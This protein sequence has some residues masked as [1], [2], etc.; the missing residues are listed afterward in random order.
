MGKLRNLEHTLNPDAAKDVIA[1]Q[2]AR[3]LYRVI[4]LENGQCRFEILLDAVR[5][6]TLRTAVDAQTADW[7]RQTQYDHATPL[8][9][10][11]RTTE[12]INAHALTRIA[13]IF[14][15]APA[16]VREANFNPPMLF[17]TP[18]GKDP[19]TLAE[20]VYGTPVPTSA[21]PHPEAH[22]LELDDTGHP[23]RLDGAQI[24]T[25]PHTRLASPAQRTA[26]AHRDRHCTEPGCTRPPTFA[27][28]AHHTIPHSKGGPTTLRN[29][30]LLCSPHHTLAH[31]HQHQ[32]QHQQTGHDPE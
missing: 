28:H 16:N 24:D 14:L 7:I 21:I 29:M 20:T 23:T 30:V 26:L 12:Q 6:T 11:I 31:Q 19:N 13:E 18:A 10:D 17:S 3:S 5:A 25:D 8:P 2:R 4:E 1:R 22:T 15:T 9:D 32:H 27:L